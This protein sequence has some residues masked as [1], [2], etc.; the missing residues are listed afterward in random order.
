MMIRSHP[1]IPLTG[2]AVIE[3]NVASVGSAGGAK[4]NEMSM[5]APGVAVPLIPF[6]PIQLTTGVAD[7]LAGVQ[8]ETIM[9]SG[10]GS[11]IPSPTA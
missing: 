4:C 6:G 3:T 9:I 8:S 10:S 11:Q 5:V 7:V 1:Q 2:S